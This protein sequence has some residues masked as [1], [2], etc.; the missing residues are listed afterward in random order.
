MF[1]RILDEIRSH[2]TV[3]IHRHSSPDGDAIGSQVGLK[4]IIKAN[5]PE[6]TVLS[7]GDP[8]GR[9]SFI[10]GSTPD[11]VSDEEYKDALAIILDTASRPLISDDRYSLAHARAR[12]DHH[13]FCEQ[14]AEYEVIDTSFESCCGLVTSFAYETGLEIPKI[15]AAALYTGMVTDSGRFQY[16]STS[17]KSFK[18][19][20]VLMEKGIDI[21]KIYSSLYVDD[22]DKVLLRA[23]F[24]QKI[25]NTQ[26]GVAYI[27]TDI[28][29]VKSFG[30]D[31][32]SISRGMVSTMAGIRGI[33]SWV[34]FTETENG[35]LC[36]LRSSKY[37]INPVAVKY[38]GGGHQ[39]AS[40]CTVKNREEAMLLLED[41]IKICEESNG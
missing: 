34:N 17:S 14:I 8:A 24:V 4:E 5:F 19:A 31:T 40:G 22:F 37:N 11:D 23:K 13:I 9:Y 39:K 7:V 12:F 3:I 41:M 6:K 33:D 2:N 29:E 38:G 16:D 21:S 28:D 20:A 1:Q 26:K 27:Y 18:M 25:N 30:V 32:F 10:E 15:A 36:E 35:V